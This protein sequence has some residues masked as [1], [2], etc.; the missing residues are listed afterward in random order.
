MPN[1]TKKTAN[2]SRRALDDNE[3]LDPSTS[4][5]KKSC[6]SARD[7]SQSLSTI[8]E[9]NE[10]LTPSNY[11]IL[12]TS[13]INENLLLPLVSNATLPSSINLQSESA[14][15]GNILSPSVS[16]NNV[17]T[18]PL[19]ISSISPSSSDYF[20]AAPTRMDDT[21]S[22]LL[23]YKDITSSPTTNNDIIMAASVNHTLD[24]QPTNNN[25]NGRRSTSNVWRYATK[26]ED[27]KTAT[28]HLCDFKCATSGHSTST[29]RYHL[30]RRHNKTELII[31]TE[32]ASAPKPAISSFYKKEL[33]ALCYNA[34]VMDHR[35]FN[36]LRKKGITM[37]F[38]KMCAGYVPPHR[39]QV[40]MELRRMYN[41]EYQLLKDELKL[42]DYIGITLDSWSTRSGISYLCITGHWYDDKA[43][44]FSKI[45]HFAAF[46]ERH[47]AV[48][49]ANC[50]KQ[51]LM[52]LEIYN[53]VIRI[54]CGGGENL[55]AAC[56]KLD[57]PTKRIWC[58]AHRLHL[59]VI[60]AL[61]FWNKEKKVDHN[62]TVEMSTET[63]PTTTNDA[64]SKQHGEMTHT[65]LSESNTVSSNQ[66]D[67]DADLND[68]IMINAYDE[69]QDIEDK[70][71]PDQAVDD[72]SGTKTQDLD[73]VYDN[74]STTV[75]VDV[76]SINIIQLNMNILKKCRSIA[77]LSKKSY[78]VSNVLRASSSNK[79]KKVISNVCRSRWNSTFKLI[80]SIT[81]N[82]SS[83]I[84]LFLEKRSLKLR[85]EQL[86][87]LSD[88]ELSNE[89]WD[90]L[91]SL[92]RVLKPFACSTT[93]MSGKNYPTIGLAYHAIHKLKSFCEADGEN[94]HIQELKQLLLAK[95]NQYFYS[96]LEQ[97]EHFKKHAFF[98][99]S[100]HMSFNEAEKN[101][102]EKYVRTLV[103]NDLYPRKQ[104]RFDQTQAASSN[105]AAP[106]SA[107]VVPSSAAISSSTAVVPALT[108]TSLPMQ[109]S[110]SQ[111]ASSK[112]SAYDEFLAAC[113]EQDFTQETTKEKSKRIS[114][115]DELK[116]F[117]L[118][119][120]E[121]NAK[122][123][124]S[125]SSILEFW[126]T[127]YIQFPLLWNLARVHLV[128]CGTSVA[129]ES[130]F[131]CSAYVARKERSRLT[132]DNLAFSVFL[133]DKL[134]KK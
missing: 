97:F 78:I 41:Q 134:D 100:A 35:P 101:Q 125:T 103:L 31:T 59:V 104:P 102:F 113:G 55:I 16:S 37:V 29:I 120:Q 3:N 67:D 46:N 131:S 20:A 77:T 60:N 27:G 89:D 52:E 19:L 38:Q 74:W 118:A 128:A 108:T 64:V 68:V 129:S 84:K 13:S 53:K 76:P 126:K 111:G 93:M 54:T 40:S 80:N 79:S 4:V 119:V 61:G 34:I 8:D 7:S 25:S 23:N 9:H 91:N 90:F 44:F 112:Q 69:Y 127:H 94:E 26:S 12:S 10:T 32:P 22:Q 117:R 15:N 96:D 2:K 21:S 83:I 73:L 110:T 6:T 72:N 66:I 95:I 42:I 50:I 43:D 133:K 85:K 121:F 123:R 36:D 124:P 65:N 39:N 107:A 56:K 5:S 82:K 48:N 116:Y 24:E 105:A 86:D 75:D 70:D 92:E 11:N 99:P 130:A 58:C 98:D 28:C 17:N 30:I 45:I 63:P 132:A 115:N 57:G 81:E 106:S 18:L 62:Q 71:E 14:L 33:H 47:T 122:H 114:L 51:I 49:I 87:K 1:N 88:I 109:H